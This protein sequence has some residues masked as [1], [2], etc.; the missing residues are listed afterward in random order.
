MVVLIPEYSNMIA[1]VSVDGMGTDGME[2]IKEWNKW[3]GEQVNARVPHCNRANIISE[4]HT[5]RFKVSEKS[6]GQNAVN[7]GAGASLVDAKKGTVCHCPREHQGTA[8]LPSTYCGP[9][10]WGWGW[11][12]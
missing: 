3:D 11:C 12:W 9:G 5:P 8:I 2:W 4:G 7:N 6:T 1:L 10:W